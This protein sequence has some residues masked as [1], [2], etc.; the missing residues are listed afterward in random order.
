MHHTVLTLLVLAGC[1]SN[2]PTPF[3]GK[4][5]LEGVANSQGYVF[6]SDLT[7]DYITI[8]SAVL[9]SGTFTYDATTLTLTYDDSTTST[10][11]YS[12]NAAQDQL[13]L[14]DGVFTWLY[15]KQ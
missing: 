15:V 7:F 12:F 1:P 6:R 9:S 13:T 2:P 11:T 14:D 10:F 4:W 8:L 3:D 5:W